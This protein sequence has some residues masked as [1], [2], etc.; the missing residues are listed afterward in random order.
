MLA[1]APEQIQ[2]C[3]KYKSGSS[4]IYREEK[5]DGQSDF[6]DVMETRFLG[7]ISYDQLSSRKKQKWR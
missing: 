3:E 5:V 6:R 1:A 4:N 7:A 2:I